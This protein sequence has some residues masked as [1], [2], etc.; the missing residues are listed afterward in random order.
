MRDQQQRQN[1]NGFVVES[2][3][4]SLAKWIFETYP[5]TALNV[6]SQNPKLRTYYMNVLFAGSK[7]EWLSSKLDSEKKER[8][9]C[10]AR[11][12]EL[13]L[14]VKKLE[15]AMSGFKAELGKISNGLSYLTQAGFKVE[16][17]WSKLDT[18]YLGRKK[19]N[20]C[21]ARIV[22]LKQ[23]L[24]KLER[25]MS[26]VKVKLRN[27]KAK[28]NPTIAMMSHQN[29]I[30]RNQQLRRQI[31]LSQLE[32]AYLERNKRNACEAGRIV[33]VKQEVKKLE[34]EVSGLEPE[35]S[36]LK[37]ELKNEEPKLK[38]HSSFRNLLRCLFCL[39]T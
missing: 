13:K 19:R 21:E 5:E 12:V 36:G 35:V 33:K 18:A 28:L 27:E 24:E 39:K 2:W 31:E 7:V 17:L 25:T 22:E 11:I 16:W 26:G 30:M 34:P 32:T 9:A 4:V 10:E 23:E 15:G 6:Q 8:D 3:Q 37:A 29:G 14:K 38:K 1:V 20:A